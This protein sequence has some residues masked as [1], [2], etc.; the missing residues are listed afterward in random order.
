MPEKREKITRTKPPIQD[1]RPDQVFYSR[2]PLYQER[3]IGRA[4]VAWSRLE[5]AMQDTIWK[6]LDIPIEQGR[7]LTARH[8]PESLILILRTLGRASL[9][10]DKANQF[11]RVLDLID[12]YREDRNFIVHGE[13]GILSPDWIPTAKSLRPKSPKPDE[14]VSETFS[15]ERMYNL[16]KAMDEAVNALCV[17]QNWIALRNKPPEPHLKS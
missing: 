1:R 8:A 17:I 16:I 7:L 10:V 12:I 3:L 2:V 13:W 14:L 4:V 11:D 15:P 6:F 9:S 5:A